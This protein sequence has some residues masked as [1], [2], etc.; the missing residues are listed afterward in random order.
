MTN[1][2]LRSYGFMD[3]VIL[4]VRYENLVILGYILFEQLEMVIGKQFPV[5]EKTG[6]IPG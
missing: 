6:G 4:I 2:P 3:V 5:T 1:F